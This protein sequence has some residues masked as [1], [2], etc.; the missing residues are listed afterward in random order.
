MEFECE[1]RNEVLENVTVIPRSLRDGNAWAIRILTQGNLANRKEVT[2]GGW[3][4]KY[5]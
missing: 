1:N 3:K 5:C 2:Y 4:N